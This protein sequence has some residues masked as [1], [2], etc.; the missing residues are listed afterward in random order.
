MHHDAAHAVTN[1]KYNPN[2][3]ASFVFVFKMFVFCVYLYFTCGKREPPGSRCSAQKSPQ[4]IL[5]LGWSIPLQ[6]HNV[7]VESLHIFIQ[8]S[9]DNLKAWGGGVTDRAHWQL[10]WSRKVLRECSLPGCILAAPAGV[11]VEMFWFVQAPTRPRPRPL[12]N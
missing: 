10:F 6:H 7:S 3:K 1:I 11:K 8:S 4:S 2:P 5:S 9:S 12:A